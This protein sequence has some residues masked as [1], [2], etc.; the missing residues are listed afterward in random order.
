MGDSCAERNKFSWNHGFFMTRYAAL[1][2]WGKSLEVFC[3]E[4]SFLAV[5]LPKPGLLTESGK[6]FPF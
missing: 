5:P 1:F 3:V 4:R 2:P 6:S